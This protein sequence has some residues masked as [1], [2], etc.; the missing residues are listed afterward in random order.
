MERIT[1]PVELRDY[2]ED[3]DIA[4]RLFR[5]PGLAQADLSFSVYD[6]DNSVPILRARKNAL[7]FGD[8]TTASGDK[9][10]YA[11]TGA[12]QQ[13]FIRYNVTSGKWEIYP[14][15]S[16]GGGPEPV[17]AA[18]KILQADVHTD[19]ES[20]AP[21][22][23]D[24]IVANSTPKWARFPKGAA[25]QILGVQASG[26]TLEWKNIISLLTA[27]AGISISGSTVATI[28][29]AGVL[30]VNAMTGAVSI[31]GTPN[32]VSVSSGG[33]TVT[34][35]LP[36]NI[37]TA[38]T[39]TFAG[40]TLTGLT[41]VLFGNGASAVTALAATGALQYLR[42]N[43]ANTAY[44]FATISASDI[45]HNLLSA[46]HPDT[47][48]ASP[49]LGD[50]IAANSTPKWQ[51]IP[52]NTTTTKKFLTQT[53]TGTAS[54]LPVWDVIAVTDLPAHASRHQDGGADEINVTGLS[55]LLADAQ[56]VSVAKNSGAIIGTR[57]KLNFIEGIG[58]TLTITD[59]AANQRVNV[60]INSAQDIATDSTPTFYAL[61][62]TSGL[63]V[64]GSPGL[65]GIVT[66]HM[67]GASNFSEG[68]RIR[69]RG[70]TSDANGAVA[71]NA[72]LGYH[73]F[74]G[75]DGSSYA[76]GAF[77]IAKTTEAWN[78]AA[79]GTE[80]S[81]YTTPTG[82]TGNVE[83]LRINSNGVVQI[84][85]TL[86]NA[87]TVAGGIKAGSGGVNIIDASGR[88]PALTSTYFASLDASSLLATLTMRK[89]SSTVGSPR[90]QMNFIE[91]TGMQIDVSDT[92]TEFAITPRVKRMLILP[93]PGDP[94]AGAPVSVRIAAPTSGTITAIK[95]ICTVAATT[96]YTYDIN[97]NGTTIYTTQGNRPTRTSA[98]GTALVTASMPDVT[99]FSAGDVFE[100]DLDSKGTGVKDVV[101]FI[102]YTES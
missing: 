63:S 85:S 10:I 13:P 23:G 60:T 86:A 34:L 100:V 81:I 102:H 90:R 73:S 45:P 68:L 61:N 31:V 69:K 83:C 58:I 1:D 87:L 28:A 65:F 72:E 93:I 30:S 101:F 82:G 43:A 4:L 76:R 14:A 88:I 80:L 66:L 21:V 74:Y 67:Q 40:I 32:Q 2:N 44:E 33:G 77:I 57:Q 53:G 7:L 97:K 51:R 39:P 70:N 38:A 25:N 48:A 89:N 5:Q 71:A 35:S 54:A 92:G 99:S 3:Y 46:P 11:R 22:Q 95:H 37:H 62:I 49:V 20:G 16:G 26:A 41:G 17:L 91:T 15:P 75:W 52:G 55:G 98:H 6:A 19:T 64:F 8:G 50:I 84:L 24:L 56:K 78:S 42:R 94:N 96:T 36:Q 47:V 12:A 27:G 59:D 29:N 79:H 9:Y 18:H